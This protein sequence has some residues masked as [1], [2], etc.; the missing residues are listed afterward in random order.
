MPSYIWFT[1]ATAAKK[2]RRV[3]DLRR[4]F[5]IYSVAVPRQRSCR[6]FQ[7]G[8]GGAVS[9]PQGGQGAQPLENFDILTPS[10]PLKCHINALWI[11][12]FASQKVV[13]DIKKVSSEPFFHCKTQ[14]NT[15][16]AQTFAVSPISVKFAKVHSPPKIWSDSSANVYSR[17]ICLFP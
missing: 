6:A 8:S 2:C 13:F 1:T 7:L 15:L 9:P 17:E 14:R 11:T 3:Y 10:N 12:I 4:H 5:L 16:R